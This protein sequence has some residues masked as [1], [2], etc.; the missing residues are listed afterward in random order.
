MF[1]VCGVFVR[2]VFFFLR[3]GLFSMK[4]YSVFDEFEK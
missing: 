3:V 1:C 2:V 4:C